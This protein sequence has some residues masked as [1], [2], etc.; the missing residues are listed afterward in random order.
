[1]RTSF[2]LKPGVKWTDAAGWIKKYIGREVGSWAFHGHVNV[3]TISL[4]GLPEDR[5]KQMLELPDCPVTH[6]ITS[7]QAEGLCTRSKDLFRV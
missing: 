7:D 6:P 1:M 2:G 3:L 4:H 5:F